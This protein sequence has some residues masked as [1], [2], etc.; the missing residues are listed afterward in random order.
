MI[1]ALARRGITDLS[2]M[3]LDTW[4][5]RGALIPEKYQGRRV[6][7]VDAWHRETAEGNPYANPVNGLHFV[8]DLNTHEAARGRGLASSWTAR[9]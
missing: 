5:Y 8:V 6:G 7:W 3:F 9:R 1:E 4:G 2:L